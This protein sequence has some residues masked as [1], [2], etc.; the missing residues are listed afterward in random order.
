MRYER[1]LN[2]AMDMYLRFV[3]S[4]YQKEFIEVFLHPRDILQIPQAVNAI[5][6]GNIGGSFAINWRM[7]IFYLIVWLQRYAPLCP[8]LTLLPKRET[9]AV[10]SPSL[11]IVP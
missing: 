4:W 9:P 10:P 7:R 3:H 5:L 2:K 6:G 11:E 8:R 1:Q